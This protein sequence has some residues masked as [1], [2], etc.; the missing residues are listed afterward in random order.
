MSTGSN[1][2]LSRRNFLKV[3]A[4]GMAAAG[5]GLRPAGAAEEAAKKKKIPIGLQLYSVRE[6]CAKDL[7]PVLEAVGK[8][9]YNGVEFAGYYGRQA[10]E[11]RKLLDGNGLVC[12]GTHTALNTVTG[13]ALKP[14][15]EFNK[16]LGNKFLIV[17][18][19]PGNLTGSRQ[20]WLDAAKLFNELADKVKAEEMLVGYHAHGGDFKKFDGEFAWDIL[21]G[22]TKPEVVM[23]LDLG[24]CMDG[25]G[26]PVAELK[27]FPRRA[28]TIHLKEHGG[29]A[30]TVIGEG[31]VKWKEIF[32]LCEAGGTQWYIVEHERKSPD[33]VEEVKRCLE[34]LRKMG[35]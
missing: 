27:K 21:F 33:P 32:E 31:D 9:G 23:Q 20:A 19:M 30:K 10:K 24:N 35:K 15:I 22:A 28:T 18:S 3:G 17:P 7:P 12:C 8:M 6:Q 4:A 13:D 1:Y 26:D 14:T 34:G 5:L 2:P 11:L 29:D 16:I 25:G